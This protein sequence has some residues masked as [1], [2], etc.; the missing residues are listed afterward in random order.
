[1]RRITVVFI[2]V[3]SV[4]MTV[5][6]TPIN[7]MQSVDK[8][9]IAR[10]DDLESSV[11]P[12]AMAVVYTDRITD[13][14]RHKGIKKIE[15]NVEKDSVVFELSDINYDSKCSYIIYGSVA[16]GSSYEYLGICHGGQ[17]GGNKFKVQLGTFNSFNYKDN[18]TANQWLPVRG[19]I[20]F[21]V[22]KISI[23]SNNK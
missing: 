2:I 18:T 19:R 4:L 22:S 3:I 12:V 7:S 16:Y 1:M 9:L 14:I 15:V 6:Y 11:T 17:I 10:I 5:N 21:Q 8:G 13:S 23:S 20:V